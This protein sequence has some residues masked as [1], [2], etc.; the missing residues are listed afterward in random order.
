MSNPFNIINPQLNSHKGE[1]VRLSDLPADTIQRIES[2]IKNN[3]VVLFMKGN[4]NMPQCGFS[5]NVVQM[6]GQLEGTYKTYDILLDQ[7][8][9]AAIKDYSNWPTFP[10]LYIK[11]E[12]VGGNDIISELFQQGELQK[13]LAQ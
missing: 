11:G 10:Q 7:D 4:P 12:L 8:L 3:D 9:R 2:L 13:L 5:A 1:E 6:L